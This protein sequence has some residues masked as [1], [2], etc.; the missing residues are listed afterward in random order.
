[1]FHFT[2]MTALYFGYEKGFMVKKSSENT[3]KL[4]QGIVISTI[5]WSLIGALQALFNQ[6]RNVFAK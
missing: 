2:G 1:M 6:L 3:R 5:I 4:L